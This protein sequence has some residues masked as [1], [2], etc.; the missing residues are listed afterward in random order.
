MAARD[1]QYAA[2]WLKP[3]FFENCL[4]AREPPTRFACDEEVVPYT[5]YRSGAKK[6]LSKKTREGL[7]FFT[8]ATSYK[9]YD[10][11]YGEVRAP[12]EEGEVLGKII[13]GA[14]PASGGYVLNY[15]I[16]GEKK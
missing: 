6:Q 9:G 8:L 7:E 2:C 10:R 3:K 1:R 4:H 11:Y 13:R 12:A 15:I 16:Q 5:G 14:D